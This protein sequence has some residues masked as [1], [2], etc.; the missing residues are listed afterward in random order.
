[1]TP[2]GRAFRV[3]QAFLHGPDIDRAAEGLS[4]RAPPAGAGAPDAGVRA[5]HRAWRGYRGRDLRAGAVA[6]GG[7]RQRRTGVAAHRRSGAASLS[8]AGAVSHLSRLASS[9]LSDPARLADAGLAMAGARRR[10]GS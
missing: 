5:R 3:P 2:G 9:A 4:R 6:Q 1:M 8:A 10:A 7:P